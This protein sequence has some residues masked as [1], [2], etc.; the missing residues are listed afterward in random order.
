[1]G[2]DTFIDFAGKIIQSAGTFI[3]GDGKIEHDAGAYYH[4]FGCWQ[5]LVIA[6]VSVCTPSKRLILT[7]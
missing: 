6:L 7:K 1:V 5:R 2:T 3:P 4:E